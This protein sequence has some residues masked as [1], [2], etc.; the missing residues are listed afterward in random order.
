MVTEE[1]LYE[2]INNLEIEKYKLEDENEMLKDEIKHL[3]EE[4][5]DIIQDKDENYRPISKSEQYDVY[6]NMFI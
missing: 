6:D 3:K 1:E 4:I 5:E 2:R